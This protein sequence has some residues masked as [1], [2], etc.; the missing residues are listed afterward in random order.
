MP[1]TTGPICGDSRRAVVVVRD[2]AATARAWGT[3]SGRTR[4]AVERNGE[5]FVGSTFGRRALTAA[6]GLVSHAAHLA[7]VAGRGRSCRGS[8]KGTSQSDSEDSPH[9][10]ILYA[11]LSL[12]PVGR[13]EAQP[14]TP[15][16][17]I[18]SVPT[19]VAAGTVSRRLSERR[20]CRLRDLRDQFFAKGTGL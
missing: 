12:G 18:S 7:V 9:T 3:R 8:Q 19:D 14:T 1:W 11:P 15:R 2:I 20:I 16:P 5:R 6:R 10:Y 4:V 13:H 17:W